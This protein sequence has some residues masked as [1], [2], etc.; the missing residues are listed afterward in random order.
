LST[1]G[2]LVLSHQ[3]LAVT[4][5]LATRLGGLL[6]MTPPLGSA[7]IPATVRVAFVFAMAAVLAAGLPGI[8]GLDT[9]DIGTLVVAALSEFA[10]GA[11]MSLGISLGFAAFAVGARL[12]DVQIGFGIGQVFD[13]LTRQQLPVL[14]GAFNQLALVLFFAAD[15][16]V[17]LL[18][19]VALSIERFPPGSAWPVEAAVGPLVQQVA[20]LFALGFTLVAPIVLCLVLVELGLGVL[21]RNLPQMNT[22]VLG[23]PVKVIVGLAALSIWLAASSGVVSRTHTAMFAGWEALFR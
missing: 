3:W 7:S 16:H 19:G 2:T 21:S 5:L 14:S 9:L 22:F 15:G 6:L 8:P 20:A 11:T 23:I 12:I 1:A 4:M 18:R 10:L 13:P 17:S